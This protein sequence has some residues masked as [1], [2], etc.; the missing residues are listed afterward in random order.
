MLKIKVTHKI[1][2]IVQS[3]FDDKKYKVI[4]Y[5]YIESQWIKYACMQDKE[6]LT[7]KC[8]IELKKWKESSIWFDIT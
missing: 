2:D 8:D 5:N 6:E 4:W 7:Y 1:W 3:S